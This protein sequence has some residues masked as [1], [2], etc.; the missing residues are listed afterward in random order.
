MISKKVTNII[1][2][3]LG[4][5]IT[6][7]GI[8]SFLSYNNIIT[9]GFSGLA[10][11]IHYLLDFEIGKTLFILNLPFFIVGAKELGVTRMINSLI[12]VMSLSFWT[13]FLPRFSLYTTHDKLLASIFGGVLIGVGLGVVF[14]FNGTTGGTDIIGKI[15]EKHTHFKLGQCIATTNIIIIIASGILFNFEVALYAII[16]TFTTGKVVDFVQ[17]G[18]NVSKATF[19]ISDKPIDIK[20]NIYE[21]LGRGVT[22]LDG[23]GGFTETQKEI[24][25]CTLK[26]KEVPKLKE[27]VTEIDNNAFIILTS[28]H[29]VLGNGF[30]RSN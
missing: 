17:Q 13:D 28:V 22:L 7:L 9:G 4:T 2:I 26:S 27:A 6:A 16:T 24:I 21:N 18:L 14:R 8:T 19:I 11:M 15:I 10:L 20:H 23:K 3:I 1:G 30:I 12:A 25:L 29:E 5:S